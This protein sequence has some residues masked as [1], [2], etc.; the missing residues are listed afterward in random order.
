MK[1][2]LYEEQKSFILNTSTGIKALL[3][4]S[5]DTKEAIN[6][7]ISYYEFLEHDYFYFTYLYNKTR[8][9]ENIHCVVI[10]DP[11]NINLLICELTNPY[12]KSYT[13][14]LIKS[15]DDYTLEILAGTDRYNLIEKILN[16]NLIG[17]K[18]DDYFYLVKDLDVSGILKNIEK[19]FF[20]VRQE[21]N[22]EDKSYTFIAEDIPTNLN[23]CKLLHF[24][25]ETDLITPFITDYYYQSAIYQLF[26]YSNYMITLNNKKYNLKDTFFERVK[27]LSV[28][29]VSN[30]LKGIIEDSELY[31][32]HSTIVNELIKKL[33]LLKNDTE[34]ELKEIKIN[35][36]KNCKFNNNH[37]LLAYESPIKRIMKHFIENRLK[38]INNTKQNN[39]IKCY[40]NFVFIK[41][42]TSYREY[43]DLM[44]L[45]SEKHKI[46]LLSDKILK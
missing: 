1:D 45:N 13:I 17:I 44:S 27:F 37:L 6:N 21:Y 24:E 19:Y 18:Q 36:E 7:I 30:E 22:L 31:E 38:I 14:L 11:K 42:G 29:K 2:N 43:R 15:V 23:S 3:F 26:D 4:D 46:Y 32:K 10:L 9:P 34:K 33:D 16:I 8:K 20:I 25:R 5:D 40:Y 28:D 12:Y 41:G 35:K 39:I